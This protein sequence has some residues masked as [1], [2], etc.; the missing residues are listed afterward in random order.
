VVCVIP[1][2]K[3]LPA[4][5]LGILADTFSPTTEFLQPYLSDVVFCKDSLDHV[6]I[7]L[8][9]GVRSWKAAHVDQNVDFVGWAL[10][11]VTS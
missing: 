10:R 1:E 11:R 5:I 3:I 2:C 9:I 8:R 7:E 4:G 6:L